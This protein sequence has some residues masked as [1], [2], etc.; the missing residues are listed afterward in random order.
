MGCVDSGVGTE[1]NC[2][3]EGSLGG[4]WD[5]AVVAFNFAVN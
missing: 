3:L 2:I 4:V 5:K 1:I